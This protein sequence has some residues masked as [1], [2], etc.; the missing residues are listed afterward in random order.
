MG[1]IV[2]ITA[3]A[4]EKGRS[5]VMDLLS[6]LEKIG[7]SPNADEYRLLKD[8]E[9]NDIILFNPNYEV[10]NHF[11]GT[12]LYPAVVTIDCTT[13]EPKAYA[14]VSEMLDSNVKY[15]SLRTGNNM[16]YKIQDLTKRY[17][18]VGMEIFGVGD[19]P[20]AI[21]MIDDMFDIEAQKI[22]NSI[23]KKESLIKATLPTERLASIASYYS[24]RAVYLHDLNQVI[25]FGENANNRVMLNFDYELG[26]V[27]AY[28]KDAEGH[29]TKVYDIRDTSQGFAILDNEEYR[30]ILKSEAMRDIIDTVGLE[31]EHER[32]V[33]HEY[34][35]ERSYIG[36]ISYQLSDIGV[37]ELA[38][39][40]FDYKTQFSEEL[41]QKML[42]RMKEYS[43]AVQD[44]VVVAYN[45]FN[46]TL[47]LISNGGQVSISFDEFG[48][49]MDIYYKKEHE[50]PHITNMIIDNNRIASDFAKTVILEDENFKYITKNLAFGINDI[51]RGNAGKI[52]TE[53]EKAVKRREEKSRSVE[54]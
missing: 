50:R 16:P 43:E 52:L 14:T 39:M 44:D 47:N 30:N 35:E 38:N 18:T 17:N 9:T 31:I 6:V 45:K 34:S 53:A 32:T 20:K 54:R 23:E 13:N 40:E 42:S 36:D 28:F 3:S 5:A 11:R 46:N 8:D 24:D 48:N 26:L 29:A 22:T 12:A 21:K 37:Y 33:Q 4:S 10:N 27:N 15:A 51:A 49:R 1:I 41:E 2:I 7:A 25:L 19:I